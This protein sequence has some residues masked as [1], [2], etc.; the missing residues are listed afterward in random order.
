[1]IDWVHQ[2]YRRKSYQ[3]L[4]LSLLINHGVLPYERKVTNSS[5]D[6]MLCDIWIKKSRLSKCVRVCLC[7][8]CTHARLY[9]RLRV[10]LWLSVYV[11]KCLFVRLSSYKIGRDAW[12]RYYVSVTNEVLSILLDF[13]SNTHPPKKRL[14][15]TGVSTLWYYLQNELGT[16]NG[17]QTQI[18]HFS[19]AF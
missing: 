1:M 3:N 19:R 11:L 17:N 10:C 16:P 15:N 2:E 13:S 6:I 7:G 8:E 5:F 12:I 18:I 4:W 9:V 14:L